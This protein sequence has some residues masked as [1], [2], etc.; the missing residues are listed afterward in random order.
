MWGALWPGKEAGR[1]A[2]LVGLVVILK[3][4]QNGW[5]VDR[6]RRKPTGFAD[7]MDVGYESKSRIKDEAKVR[8]LSNKDGVSI[9]R[10]GKGCHEGAGK[11]G[12]SGVVLDVPR[13]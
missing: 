3:V 9:Y 8:G 6:P 4:R 2:G 12:R 5:N 7:G 13:A 1:P 11:A 10:D